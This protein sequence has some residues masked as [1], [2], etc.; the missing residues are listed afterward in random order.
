[1][2]EHIRSKRDCVSNV[3]AIYFVEPTELNIGMILEVRG[4]YTSSKE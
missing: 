3:T 2:M 1:M 4:F